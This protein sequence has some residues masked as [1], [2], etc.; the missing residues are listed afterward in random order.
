MG[1]FIGYKLQ[2]IRQILSMSQQEF[3]D[4]IGISRANLSQI[5]QGKQNPTLEQLVS[6]ERIYFIPFDYFFKDDEKLIG[7]VNNQ[8]LKFK[9]VTENPYFSSVT[10]EKASITAKDSIPLIPVNA[11]AGA[12]NGDMQVLE[13]ECER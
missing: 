12:F 13:H 3:G 7:F 10:S 4:S 8:L 9:K 1:L 6:I 2:S 11:M 5:E